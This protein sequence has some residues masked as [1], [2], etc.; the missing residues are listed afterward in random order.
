ME[1]GKGEERE[2]RKGEGIYHT[3]KEALELVLF[4]H[5]RSR[6]LGMNLL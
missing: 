1:G 3:C 2:G 6:E 5:L 4:Y